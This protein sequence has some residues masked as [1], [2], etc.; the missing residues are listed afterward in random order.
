LAAG[1]ISLGAF[2]GVAYATT[3]PAPHTE[4]NVQI[5]DTAIKLSKYKVSDVTFVDFYIHNTGKLSHDMRIGRETSVAVRPGQRVHF[6][7]GFPVYGWYSFRV[8]LHGTAKMKGRFHINA[9]QPPD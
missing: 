2:G 4:V 6:Y 7:V 9:P 3:G 5:S 1:V 8:H